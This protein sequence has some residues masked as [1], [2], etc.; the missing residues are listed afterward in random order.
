LVFCFFSY[1]VSFLFFF[2]CS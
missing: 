1:V 2:I